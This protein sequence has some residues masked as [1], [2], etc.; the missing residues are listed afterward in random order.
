MFVKCVDLYDAE[1]RIQWIE[2]E[3][4]QCNPIILPKLGRDLK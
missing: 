4:W 2:N 3:E 1:V